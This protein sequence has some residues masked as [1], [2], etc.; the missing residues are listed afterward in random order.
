MHTLTANKAASTP[1]ALFSSSNGSERTV[2]HV[3]SVAIGAGRPVVIA[4]PCS[5]ESYGQLLATAEAVKSA[6]AAILRG[7]AYKPRT[8]P[9]DF[10]G[11]GVEALEILS[12]VR[13]ETGLPVVS[14]VVS[15][16]EVEMVAEHVD[17]LQVGARNMQ[18]FALLKRLGQLRKTGLVKAQP[19]SHGEGVVAGG[20]I[21]AGRRQRPGG[22][23][24]TRHPLLRPPTSQHARSGGPGAGKA[25]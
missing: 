16:D 2:V 24:R 25:A 18:N 12:Q 3:G 6:G 13:D 19:R 9:Y 15:T 7:G 22:A 23:V 10:Q 1:L 8:S 14:E 5:V 21:S 4:G 20:G 17:M 11:L